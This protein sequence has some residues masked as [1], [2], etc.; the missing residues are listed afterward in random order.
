L[1]LS[2]FWF[3]ATFERMKNIATGVLLLIVFACI[4]SCRKTSFTT[5]SDALLETSVDTLHFDTVFTSTGSITNRFKIF[6]ANDQKLRLSTVKLMGGAASFFK[7]NVDGLSGTAFNNI[8]VEANDSVYVFVSVSVNPTTANLPFVVQDSILISYNGND[9]FVQLDAFGQNANFLRNR[10]ISSNTVWNNDL[11]YVILGGV[12]VDAGVTLTIDQG[13]KVYAHADAPIVI[14][15]TL[16][17]LGEKYDSTKVIFRGDRLDP[18]FRDYPGSWPGIYFSET[19]NN[20]TLTYAEIRNA[21]QGIIS[22]QPATNGAPKVT[23]NECII[24]NIYDA[25]I[26]SLNSSITARNCLI[27]NCGSNVA[28]GGGGDYNFNHCTIASY[29]NIFIQHKNPVLFISNSNSQNQ[30]FALNATF[31]NCIFYGDSGFVKNEV[32]VDRKGAAA[33]NVKFENALYRVTDE[34][35]SAVFTNS[36]KNEPPQFDSIDGSKRIFNFRLKDFS[37]AIN[38]G[39]STGLLFDLDGKPRGGTAGRPDIGAYEF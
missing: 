11:P 6:N 30:S 21:Y 1:R 36:I 5:A 2:R 26:I 39:L 3:F 28:I 35:T 29:G 19:S 9:R 12:E 16:K 27:S 37:P 20:N 10:R 17:V 31:R 7:L 22:Q 23:L 25:G 18:D 32:V 34:P 24:D 38:N 13:A 8:E 15:G 14:N 33:F 4:V